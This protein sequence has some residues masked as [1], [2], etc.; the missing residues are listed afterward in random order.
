[1]A[2]DRVAALQAEH[3]TAKALTD[4]RAKAWQALNSLVGRLENWLAD[5]N[6]TP[7]AVEPVVPKLTKGQLAADEVTNLRE[8]ITALRAE[9]KRVENASPPAADVKRRIPELVAQH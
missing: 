9:R 8:V 4:E 2:R 5:Q 6:R 7:S 1:A 3:D